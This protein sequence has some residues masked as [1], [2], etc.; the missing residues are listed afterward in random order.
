M[1][2]YDAVNHIHHNT[3]LVSSKSRAAAAL[4]AL[5]NL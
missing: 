3:E 2:L 5:H 4:Y 1:V